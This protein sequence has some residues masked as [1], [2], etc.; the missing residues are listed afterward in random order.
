MR[1]GLCWH[2]PL[3][4]ESPKNCSEL[5]TA[6]AQGVGSGRRTTGIS[7]PVTNFQH[8]KAV[9]AAN[10]KLDRDHGASP[11]RSAGR[12]TAQRPLTDRWG[13]LRAASA[14]RST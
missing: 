11:A 1:D 4:A 3:K 14:G 9:H 6:C 13:A 5:H 2:T 10:K 7:K 12:T 8:N